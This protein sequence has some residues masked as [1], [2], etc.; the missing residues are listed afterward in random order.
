MLEGVLSAQANSGSWP[1][2]NPSSQEMAG[3]VL[4]CMAKT[5]PPRA[6]PPFPG[7]LSLAPSPFHHPCGHAQG[8]PAPSRPRKGPPASWAPNPEDEGSWLA[9]RGA[10]L[11]SLPNQRGLCQRRGQGHLRVG[12]QSGHP[13]PPVLFSPGSV[14]DVPSDLPVVPASSL[15]ARPA[16]LFPVSQYFCQQSSIPGRGNRLGGIGQFLRT[17]RW[18]VQAG[19]LI[20]WNLT[21]WE[22]QYG[23]AACRCSG[24]GSKRSRSSGPGPQ[25]C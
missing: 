11:P 6:R 16:A 18:G 1:P 20:P 25:L 23:G 14:H 4:P 13:G 15:G 24:G 8:P 2:R 10:S 7:P 22:T 9:M 3:P 19:W 17:G 12:Q 21:G 5:G